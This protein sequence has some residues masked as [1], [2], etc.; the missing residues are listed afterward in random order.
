MTFFHL[1]VIKQYQFV[2][3]PA[4]FLNYRACQIFRFDQKMQ[5]TAQ[6]V[7]FAATACWLTVFQGYPPPGNDKR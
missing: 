6:M 5:F 7:D 4:S 2:Q 3:F 1:F